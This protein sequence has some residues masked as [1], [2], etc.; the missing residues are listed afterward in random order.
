MVAHFENIV[1]FVGL[2]V[3]TDVVAIIAAIVGVAVIVAFAIAHS[4]VHAVVVSVIVDHTVPI[5]VAALLTVFSEEGFETVFVKKDTC[6]AFGVFQLVVCIGLSRRPT[7][8]RCFPLS[9][10]PWW[11][12]LAPF[13]VSPGRQTGR[14]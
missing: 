6:G 7:A 8:W 9:G 14:R 4:S 3:K 11:P 13:L 10:R 2:T 12:C 5:V 1:T